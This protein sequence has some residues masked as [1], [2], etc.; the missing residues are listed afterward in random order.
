MLALSD[1][2]ATRESIDPVE[3]SIGAEHPVRVIRVVWA[4]SATGPLSYLERS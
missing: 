4:M 3:E 2:A 1:T